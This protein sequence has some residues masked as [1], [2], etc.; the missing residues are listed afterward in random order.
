MNTP[1]TDAN[2]LGWQFNEQYGDFDSLSDTPIHWLD[3]SK[4][5]EEELTA[6]TEQRNELENKLEKSKSYKNV[7]KRDNAELRKQ[8]TAAREEITLLKTNLKIQ[9]NHTE[10]AVQDRADE[11]IELH[12]QIHKVTEQRDEALSDLQFR[13]DLYSLQTKQLD[14]AREQ[15]DELAKAL[16]EILP[17]LPAASCDMFHH[18]KIDRHD[19]TEECKPLARYNSKIKK[20]EEAL[21]I[22]KTWK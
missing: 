7:M 12:N 18:S 15:R 21:M 1:R 13:R 16:K 6:V 19:Y 10:N 11:H 17:L 5:L 22:Y 14:D 4:M 2:D 20:A 3:F 8:L 9:T